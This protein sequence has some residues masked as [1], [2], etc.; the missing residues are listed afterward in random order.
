V[1]LTQ[2]SLRGNLQFEI[3]NLKL[4]C[5]DEPESPSTSV[6]PIHASGV[7]S[8]KREAFQPSP[9]AYII[10]TSGSTGTPKAVAIEHRNAVN[11]IYWAQEAFTREEL[12][13]V[14]FSTSLSFDLSV[15][16]LFVTLSTGGKLIIA[17]NAIELPNLP[18]R[19]EVTLINTVPSAATALLRLKAIPPSVQVINLAGEPLKTALVD[20][21]YALGTVK[22]VHDLY[23]PSET[24][25]YSTY[26]LRQAGAPATVGRPI[27][28]TQI[29]LLDDNRQ[30][31][32]LGEIGEIYIG[33]AGVARGYLHRPDLTAERFV[34][35]PFSADLNAQ[36]YRTGD[37]AR[38]QPDENLEFLGRMDHQIK[39]RGFRVEPGEIEIAL[40][41]HPGVRESAVIARED[42]AGEKRLVAYVVQRSGLAPDSAE[43]R[44]FL[45][46]KLPEH[47]VPS[48][49]GSIA[50]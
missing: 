48:P 46:T 4:V 45:Q 30:P 8:L 20:K 21:L 41:Q 19:N 22:K 9:L 16:E 38:W 12:A 1:L 14:L 42:T 34:P 17:G 36:L 5:G 6:S 27:A 15:F 28:N 31:V 33:G 11:F 29:H 32:P 40:A 23:G 13:C 43:L 2:T 3:P 37:L 49:A 50:T 10:H 47:M 39:I 7:D 44:R 24:T 18:A 25:T 35:D 26:A